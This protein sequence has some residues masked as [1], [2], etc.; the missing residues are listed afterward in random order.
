MLVVQTRVSN[1]E[2]FVI[3]YQYGRHDVTCKFSFT[4]YFIFYQE[5][6]RHTVT[7]Q[8]H[9]ILKLP[10]RDPITMIHVYGQKMNLPV[11]IVLSHRVI[12]V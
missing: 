9:V 4:N 1:E 3:G 8:N 7:K 12:F 5:M 11:T 2:C 6:K 10:H